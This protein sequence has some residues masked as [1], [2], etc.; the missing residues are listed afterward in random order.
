[1]IWL[2]PLVN[3]LADDHTMGVFHRAGNQLAYSI[4]IQFFE[5]EQ[6]MDHEYH[7]DYKDAYQHI[8]DLLSQ[9]T[10]LP[11]YLSLHVCQLTVTVEHYRGAN[12]S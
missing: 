1:M 12:L 3:P 10:S 6:L 9:K 7:G 2:I 8:L 4:L 5:V 11:G